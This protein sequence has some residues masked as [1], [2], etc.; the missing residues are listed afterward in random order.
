[1]AAACT[2]RLSGM[3]RPLSLLLAA[4]AL[5]VSA[6]AQSAVTVSGVVQRMVVSTQVPGSAPTT[7]TAPA[8][9]PLIGTVTRQTFGGQVATASGTLRSSPREIECIAQ[10]AA[11][12]ISAGASASYDVAL[13]LTFTTAATWTGDLTLEVVGRTPGSPITAGVDIDADGSIDVNA[14]PAVGAVTRAL[15][16][17]G[18]RRILVL[19]S[20]SVTNST[21]TLTAASLTM[22]VS[23]RGRPIAG[24]IN[25]V[26]APCSPLRLSAAPTL[27]GGV[28]LQVGSSPGN[29]GLLVFGL[30]PVM[31]P[32]ALAPGCF[33]T[34]SAD[35]TTNYAWGQPL[36]LD[37]NVLQGLQV[38]V[39]A[40]RFA[41][42]L[43]VSESYRLQF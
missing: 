13:E 3:A 32:L 42:G 27:D 29:L 33:W 35:V 24:Q 8:G 19:A 31:V 22:R 17:N 16:I 38:Y 43:E 34:P 37:A 7:E 9:T 2:L 15:S 4:A 41:T 23:L 40:A 25:P 28:A 30:T 1:M 11:V 10:Q 6:A 21:N 14:P 18:T 5:T 12:A 36:Y 20:T 39:Q 26:L